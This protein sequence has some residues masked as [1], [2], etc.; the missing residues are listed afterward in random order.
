M[1]KLPNGLRATLDPRKIAKY[2][3]VAEH[4]DNNGKAAFFR[5]AGFTFG[6][7]EVFRQALLVHPTINTIFSVVSGEYGTKYV[8]RCKIQTPN[9]RNPCIDTVWIDDGDGP[10][11]F[12]TAYPAK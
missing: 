9:G 10:P 11:R 2:L 3:L 4:P 5:A 1:T 12:V 7:M 6:N 8:V